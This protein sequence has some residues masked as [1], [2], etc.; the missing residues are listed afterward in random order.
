MQ[1]LILYDIHEFL[2]KTFD[3]LTNQCLVLSD[4]FGG[5]KFIFQRGKENIFKSRIYARLAFHSCDI[6]VCVIWQIWYFQLNCQFSWELRFLR[7]VSSK[8]FAMF[9]SIY[10]L[11]K[12]NLVIFCQFWT[13]LKIQDGRIFEVWRYSWFFCFLW[14]NPSKNLCRFRIFIFFVINF[15]QIK[16]GDFLTFLNN[17]KIQDLG[18]K[19]ADF[20]M[21]DIMM[22][23][24]TS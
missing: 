17:L 19:M 7:R 3:F 20:L 13:I 21:Y 23:C 5:L 16:F 15:F 4:Q 10:C 24:M 12:S 2:I 6:T 14:W 8:I 9:A 22:A 1:K 11:F 18:S